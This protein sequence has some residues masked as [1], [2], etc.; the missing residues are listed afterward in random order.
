MRIFPFL[1]QP[2]SNITKPIAW[3]SIVAQPAPPTPILN[4]NIN[5]GS[6]KILSTPPAAT[7]IIP[8]TALP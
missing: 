6:S 3:L 2:M 1:V 8:F 4:T 5:I 7:P